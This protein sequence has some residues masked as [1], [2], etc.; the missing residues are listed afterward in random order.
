MQVYV[1]F[2]RAKVERLKFIPFTKVQFL[3][4]ALNSVEVEST[5]NVFAEGIGSWSENS[6]SGRSPWF[7]THLKLEYIYL[8]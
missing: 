2:A 1:A 4:R 5:A 7:A 3:V 8:D 6:A